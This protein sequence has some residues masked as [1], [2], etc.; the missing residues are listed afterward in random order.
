MENLEYALIS[1]IVVVV[2][3][4]LDDKCPLKSL[5]QSFPQLENM[6]KTKLKVNE[7]R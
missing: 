3:P 4:W 5:H 6:E 2:L 1:W 7:L